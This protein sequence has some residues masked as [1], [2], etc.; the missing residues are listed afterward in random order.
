MSIRLMTA[1]WNTTL[2]DS[3]KLVLLALADCANDEGGCWPSMATI[4]KKCS[5]SDRTVQASIKTLV[6]KGHLTRTEKPGKGCF[7]TVHPRSDCTPEVT[8]PPK[9]TTSTPEAASDKPSRTINTSEAKA[10]SVAPLRPEHVVEEWN[11]VAERTGLKTVRK[12]SPERKR[13]LSMRIRENSLDEFMEAFD[14]IERSK[15][16]QGDNPRGWAANFD[17]LLQ[18]ASF[19]KLIEGSY[20]GR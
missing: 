1:V 12:L 8:A 16:L 15:F 3:E 10:S 20:D 4:A 7:Y 18:P 6:I 9:G 14:A 17:F 19:L 5:K 11:K 13:K 2:A